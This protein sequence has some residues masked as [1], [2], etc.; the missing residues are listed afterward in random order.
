M[1]ADYLFINTQT[2]IPTNSEAD[3]FYFKIDH[4]FTGNDT[5]EDSPRP[6]EVIA[7]N[8]T[9]NTIT[10]LNEGTATITFYQKN[11]SSHEPVTESF[12]VQVIKH[13]PKFTWN[14]ANITYY[15][16]TSIPNI[17]STTNPDCQYT[18]VSDNE[19]VAKVIDN[20]LHIYNVEETANITITQA[21]NY[22]WN[23]K[24]ETYTITPANPNNHVTFTYTQAMFNDGTITTQKVAGKSCNWDFKTSQKSNSTKAQKTKAPT[25]LIR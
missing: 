19:H 5:R 6:D 20:T 4:D 24:T 8:P 9:T 10:A 21:E 14:A 16:G 17:F 13:T 3:P 2:A 7:Y 25:Y 11:T 18:I 23:G 12:T 15:Y 1:K 22:K